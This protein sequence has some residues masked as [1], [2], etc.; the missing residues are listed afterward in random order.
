[1]FPEVVLQEGQAE[2][3]LGST[4]C[5]QGLG[6]PLPHCSLQPLIQFAYLLQ[7]GLWDNNYRLRTSPVAMTAQHF[8]H[9]ASTL[10]L[11]WIEYVVPIFKC[12]SFHTNILY[13]TK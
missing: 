8:Y 10:G 4:H 5:L 3:P 6:V 1:M 11:N 13:G 9:L 12:D 7:P 2:A